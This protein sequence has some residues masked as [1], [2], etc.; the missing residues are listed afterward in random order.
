MMPWPD[1]IS[2]ARERLRRNPYLRNVCGYGDRAPC[3][4]PFSQ[5]NKRIGA[6][7]FRIIEALLRREAHWLREKGILFIG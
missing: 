4:A 6:E 2:F 7:G 1:I 5:M 3:E